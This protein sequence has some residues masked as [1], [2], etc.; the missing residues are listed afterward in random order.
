MLNAVLT[1]FSHT[2]AAKALSLHGVFLNS[3]QYSMLSKPLLSNITIVEKTDNGDGRMKPVTLTID[4]FDMIQSRFE[5]DLYHAKLQGQL[6]IASQV[7][8]YVC[9]ESQQEI[10]SFFPQCFLLH[11][12]QILPC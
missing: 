5:R 6:L 11:H 12:E 1:Y 7:L 3:T 8:D 9:I 4:L 10:F 2:A